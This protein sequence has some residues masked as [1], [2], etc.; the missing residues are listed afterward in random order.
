MTL[1]PEDRGALAVSLLDSLD[2]IEVDVE[3]AW[4]HEVARRMD[5]T[6]SGKV[7]TIPW[8]QENLLKNYNGSCLCRR[9]CC[10]KNV[11]TTNES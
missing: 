6:R 7:K 9:T 3:V 10:D 1:P 8:R 5:E 11:G 2:E 4:R